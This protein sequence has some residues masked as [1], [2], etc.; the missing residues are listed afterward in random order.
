MMRLILYIEADLHRMRRYFGKARKLWKVAG[1]PS[2]NWIGKLC[3]MRCSEGTASR[4]IRTD[5]KP[6]T[7]VSKLNFEFVQIV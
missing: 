2:L 3:G 7:A 1:L 5:G 4:V 6:D